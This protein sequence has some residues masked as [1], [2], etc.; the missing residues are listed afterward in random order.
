VA[1]ENL[2]VTAQES[3]ASAYPDAAT[4]P[5]LLEIVGR[6]E[7][8]ALES[9]GAPPASFAG[10]AESVGALAEALRALGVGRG[11]RIAVVSPNSAALVTAFLGAA[12]VGSCAPLNPAY[13]RSELDFFLG[14]IAARILLVA[15]E[16]DTP[17]RDAARSQGI[18]VVEFCQRA[19]AASGVVTLDDRALE[20]SLS[21]HSEPQ[22]VA[23]L[24]HTSGTTSRPKL[25]PLTHGNL[26][27]SVRHV[28]AALALGPAD[29]SLTI[30]PLF[31]IHGLVAGLLA[32]L[33]A[34]GV[35]IVPPGFLAPEFPRWL[36][37]FRPTWY[38]AVPTM[39]QAIL[40]R[41]ATAEGTALRA[42]APLRFVRSSSAALSPRLIRDLETQL[43]VPVIEAY[44][45][46][47][48]AHQMASN[49]LP[50]RARKP[51]SVGPAAGPEVAILGEE[52]QLLPPDEIGEVAIRGP[53]VTEGY[54]ANP[55][56]NAEAFTGG[57]FRTGD[58][59]SLDGDGYLTLTGRLKELIN[60][61]GEKVAP[62]EVDATFAEHP[63]VAQ[64]ICFG[65]AHPI[66][67]EEV[68]AAV[69]LKPGS[70]ATPRQLRAF[71]AS[72]LAYFKVPRQI[73]IVDRI[74]VGATGK[75]QRRGLAELLDVH[76]EIPV[77]TGDATPPRTPVE[78]IVAAAWAVA[79]Q[80]DVPG[81]HESFFSLGGDS[82]LA[83]RVVARLRLQLRIE[84][85]LLAFF[86]TP[87]VAGIADECDRL[88]D[89]TPDDA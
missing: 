74:P 1:Y 88:L 6:R 60:R 28:A 3:T 41:L 44:G 69:V 32:P 23:L 66:L 25:V 18:P 71:V 89:A 86:D 14:D 51:G 22:D 56:A 16:L 42:E 82:M 43:G 54:L 49:P 26:M 11:D 73:R 55:A 78:E 68:A 10:L 24:L 17:A 46:T 30:M 13:G 79:L 15:S 63:D 39:H 47:E 70:T 83:A 45:M 64:A 31:H 12:S 20:G 53:N 38:T 59:G 75:L 87:T 80:R 48:A 4:I 29:R 35:V 61:A 85:P 27:A 5:A 34:G 21:V 36:A 77:I 50:P 40:T 76:A 58:Q 8:V 65:I 9:L 2:H 67:G 72:R 37:R 62:L 84:L 81:V 33:A 7:S 57:W 52:G 19:G